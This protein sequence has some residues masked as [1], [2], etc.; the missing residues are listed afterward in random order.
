MERD[1]TRMTFRLETDMRRTHYDL[2]KGLEEERS[3][4]HCRDGVAPDAYV[5]LAT[6]AGVCHPRPA[7]GPE[8]TQHINHVEYSPNNPDDACEYLLA[9]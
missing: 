2:E 3:S 8:L 9:T 5:I 6:I 4:K 1:R 7:F